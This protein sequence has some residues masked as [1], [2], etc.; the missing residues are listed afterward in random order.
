MA[1][2]HKKLPVVLECVSRSKHDANMEVVPVER[3]L[4]VT[5]R[6][7]GLTMWPLMKLLAQEVQKCQRMSICDVHMILV[8]L[9]LTN[10][11]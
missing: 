2:T 5:M 9:T 7:E 4:S 10:D 1:E 8:A 3:G 6:K 11:I